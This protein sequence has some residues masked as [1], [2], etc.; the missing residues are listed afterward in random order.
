MPK[1]KSVIE[2]QIE[3]KIA[4]AYRERFPV[5]WRSI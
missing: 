2:E 4:D 1:E 5:S 3:K